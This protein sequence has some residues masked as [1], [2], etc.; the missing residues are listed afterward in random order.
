M[1]SKCT[2]C[3]QEFK[4]SEEGGMENALIG[5]IEVSF[6]GWCLS[7]IIDMMEYLE[8]KMIVVKKHDENT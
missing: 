1:K 4:E 6:C 7:G 8:V 3:K 5:M 2:I